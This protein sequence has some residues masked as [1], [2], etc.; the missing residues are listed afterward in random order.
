MALG[1]RVSMDDDEWQ[2]GTKGNRV[3]NG[4]TRERKKGLVP[5]LCM[6]P[7]P[8]MVR[9]GWTKTGVVCWLICP[10]QGLLD[11]LSGRDG[12]KV[13]LGRIWKAQ[14]GQPRKAGKSW[15]LCRSNLE[16]EQDA[17]KDRET[18]KK[19]MKS[20]GKANQT[21]HEQNQPYI[22]L[23]CYKSL[24]S[25]KGGYFAVLACLWRAFLRQEVRLAHMV[26]IKRKPLENWVTEVQ[27]WSLATRKDPKCM[28]LSSGARRQPVTQVTQRHPRG[29][30]TP[31]H[32]TKGQAVI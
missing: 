30:L 18:R 11:C 14:T 25:G 26:S 12:G 29:D 28:S 19:Q 32:L 1:L 20:Q 9:G 31:W 2:L 21:K 27:A 4:R 16:L 15:F 23:I 24:F 22:H 7:H 6:V 17:L 3:G 10:T 8:A 5:A 13:S